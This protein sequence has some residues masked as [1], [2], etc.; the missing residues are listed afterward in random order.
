MDSNIFMCTPQWDGY[1]MIAYPMV[2]PVMPIENL[3]CA[4][5]YQ[6]ADDWRAACEV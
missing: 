6:V 4:Y 2:P 3:D 1:P 5:S